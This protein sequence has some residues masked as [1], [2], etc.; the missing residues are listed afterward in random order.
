MGAWPRPGAAPAPRSLL[1]A[2][3][4]ALCSLLAQ[5]QP[6]RAFFFFFGVRT[7]AHVPR[8]VSFRSASVIGMRAAM[9]HG[10]GTA[11]GMALHVAFDSISIAAAA[12]DA[13]RR[14]P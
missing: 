11:N 6:S 9:P 14:C 3:A 4:L 5:P 2:L 8:Q 13:R 12:A 10:L 7:S 1:L